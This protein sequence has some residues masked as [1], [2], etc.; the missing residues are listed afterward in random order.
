M[1]LS[2][3][4]EDKQFLFGKYIKQGLTKEEA[5]FKI[6]DHVLNLRVIVDRLRKENK[7]DKDI[8]VIFLEELERLSYQ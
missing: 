3:K 7:S 6:R 8:N 5:D 1:Q 2:L 4:T